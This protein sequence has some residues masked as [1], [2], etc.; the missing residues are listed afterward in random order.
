MYKTYNKSTKV[1]KK[2]GS[3][4]AERVYPVLKSGEWQLVINRKINEKSKIICGF[5]FKTH[6]L[7]FSTNR[8][9]FDGECNCGATLRGEMS[10][11]NEEVISITCEISKGNG[12]CGKRYLRGEERKRVAEELALKNICPELY[13]AE[14]A[15]KLMREGDLEPAHLYSLSVLRN[16]K[17]EYKSAA[18]ID[19]D[20]FI[21][22]AWMQL[23]SSKQVIHSL[24]YN[25]F[26]LY[27]WSNHQISVYNNYARKEDS[28]LSIDA[29]GGF[30]RLIHFDKSFSKVIYLY[31]LVVHTRISQ[32]SVAQ[33]LTEAH[34]T[35]SITDFLK[36]FIRTGASPPKETICD[37]SSA[38]LTGI[39]QAFVRST[40]SVNNYADACLKE[41]NLPCYVRIDVAHFKNLYV[42]FLKDV[43][44]RLSKLYKKMLHLVIVSR[45]VEEVK[46]A[47]YRFYV[48]CLSET[49]GTND[50]GSKT[51]CET[52][53]EQLKTILIEG[54]GESEHCDEIMENELTTELGK[55]LQNSL[56]AL[57]QKFIFIYY[58]L[59]Y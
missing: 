39:I 34:H 58:L 5:N 11:L 36:E 55:C 42:K 21:S 46:E 25:P 38:L 16:A 43:R 7:Y 12:R 24:Q 10:G 18:H 4:N 50:D 33:M 19:R 2:G 30:R 31:I 32:Y 3:K 40:W 53:K 22:L 54:E 49:E 29:S 37:M 41:D 20:P 1:D 17:Y 45:N 13:R 52:V 47:I 56:I 51:V 48:V 44:P 6:K 26:K 28:C 23:E 57:I 35:N 27:Y 14:N 8:G 59:P 9:T 15:D